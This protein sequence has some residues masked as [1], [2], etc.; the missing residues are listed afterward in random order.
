MT[1]YEFYMA[2]VASS[3]WQ[4]QLPCL[5]AAHQAGEAGA[6]HALDRFGTAMKK[7]LLIDGTA[8]DVVNLASNNNLAPGIPK[9]R[10]RV[11]GSQ[12]LRD[13]RATFN[14]GPSFPN[15][16][17][18]A[19]RRD[20]VYTKL[21]DGI[22][23]TMN[24][25]PGVEKTT[26]SSPLFVASHA[27][28]KTHDLFHGTLESRLP[29]IQRDGL[30]VPPSDRRVTTSFLAESS[31]A[32]HKVFVTTNPSIAEQYARQGSY[33]G[34]HEPGAIIHM[35]MTGRQLKDMGATGMH[36]GTNSDMASV[37]H[38]GN[39]IGLPSVHSSHFQ[40]FGLA[41]PTRP[42]ANQ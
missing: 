15:A 34:S 16:G 3:A 28:D 40:R 24:K 38:T 41:H 42:E 39:E 11:A 6:T 13:V 4:R 33:V 10:M 2:K 7:N 29:E 37:Q 26:S 27:M 17:T 14:S 19:H 36:G 31:P 1:P 20:H 8:D 25:T 5:I 21:S 22:Y 35:K 12:I 18:P 30:L 32:F 9:A 23:N